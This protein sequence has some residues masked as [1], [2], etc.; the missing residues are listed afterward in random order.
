MLLCLQAAGAAKEAAAPDHAEPRQEE[1][2]AEE[3]SEE[4]HGLRPLGYL[5]RVLKKVWSP[6]NGRS[7]QDQI[8]IE[9]EP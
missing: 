8:Q 6:N 9:R 4:A 2:A 5:S 7:S 1:R 3:E